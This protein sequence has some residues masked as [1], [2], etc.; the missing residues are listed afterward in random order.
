VEVLVSRVRRKIA[1]ADG[2]PLIH[3]M[4]GMGYILSE[5]APVGAD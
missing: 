1:S 3:T 4:R 5:Q 2:P